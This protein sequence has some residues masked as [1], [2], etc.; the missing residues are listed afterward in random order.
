M[1]NRRL[2]VIVAELFFSADD[3]AGFWLVCFMIFR[4]LPDDGQVTMMYSIL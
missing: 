2:V 4:G 1:G 3:A